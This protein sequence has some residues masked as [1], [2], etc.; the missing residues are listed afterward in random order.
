MADLTYRIGNGYS[1]R[2][3]A[4]AGSSMP[5][6]IEHSGS[7]IFNSAA[8]TLTL[9]AIGLA[10]D[11]D[12]EF[13]VAHA[14]EF[15]I[16][17]PAGVS[18]VYK[19]ST[20]AAAGYL[21]SSTVGD[22]IRLVPLTTTS[23]AVTSIEGTWSVDGGKTIDGS[24]PRYSKV[25]VVAKSGGEYTSTQDALDANTSGSELFLV[26]PGTY[27]DT[28]VF[29]ANN[30][31]V[32]GM[33]NGNN[34]IVTQATTNVVSFG[35][36][37]GCE[38]IDLQLSLTAATSEKYVVT[39]STGTLLIRDCYLRE[40]NTANIS[41]TQ[42]ALIYVSGAGTV[43]TENCEFEYLNTGTAT[44]SDIKAAFAAGT[45]ATINLKRSFDV[46]MTN[47]GT[48]LATTMFV[49]TGTG[50]V[51]MKNTSNAIITDPDC[52]VLAGL[53]Y[54]G[55][56]GASEFIYNNIHVVATNNAAFGIYHAGTGTLISS[57]N[58]IDVTDSAGTSNSF[59]IGASATLHST[60]DSI[61]ADDGV[62]NSGTFKMVSSQTPGDLSVTGSVDVTGDVDVTAA[63]TVGTTLDVTGALTNLRPVESFAAND[64]LTQAESGKICTNSAVVTLTLPTAVAGMV[65]T[66]VVG[67]ANY[68]RVNLSAGDTAQY[69]ATASAA[70]G[71]FRSATQ[72]D[73]VRLE[74]L[75][76]TEWYVTSLEGTWTFDS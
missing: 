63:A 58:T 66:F 38:L 15:K 67:S 60:F 55:G 47:S 73:I 18:I 11:Q 22:R 19:D 72:G 52:T 20:T 34:T 27:T 50:V 54:I 29:T 9:P 24:I 13:I 28:I 65:F 39:G 32:R 1:G 23:W 36:R 8:V 43:N 16:Q 10:G 48:A 4:E 26:A 17:A 35:T 75:N 6:D 12:Y 33:A 62:S 44:G 70:G 76:A 49:S 21:S 68:L 5:L 45:G 37:T 57:H 69:K 7:L 59:F 56:A 74:C 42:P 53:G 25:V 2:S 64:T 71:Y 30:Q 61:S 14:S 41:G 46:V 31:T 40:A 51:N 3:V